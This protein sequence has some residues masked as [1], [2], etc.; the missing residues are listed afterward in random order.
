MKVLSNTTTKVI[1]LELTQE[2]IT[3]YKSAWQTL[4]I[5]LVDEEL[6]PGQQKAVETALEVLGRLV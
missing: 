6:T 5:L 3:K 4:D 1:T 2:D